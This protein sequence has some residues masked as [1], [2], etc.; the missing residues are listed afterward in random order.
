MRNRVDFW[1][2]DNLTDPAAI[3]EIDWAR[4]RR[5]YEAGA[6]RR[7]LLAKVELPPSE[8]RPRT[9]SLVPPPHS[10]PAMAEGASQADVAAYVCE[11]LAGLIGVAASMLLLLNGRIAGVSGIL[12][13]VF[14]TIGVAERFWR[15]AFVI[16][17]VCGAFL[18]ALA[19]DG[20]TME[21]PRSHLLLLVAGFLVGVG[22]R[23][24]SGCTSGHGVCGLARRSPR[25]LAATAT[26]LLFG[27]LTVFLMRHITSF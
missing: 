23:L 3:A 9:M 17:L 18:Y 8:P 4:F 14:G 16:G 7:R 10:C 11:T 2:E 15:V 13:G 27:T 26:F 12:G 24:G 5:L 25:S 19:A 20:L 6:P 22:T 21:L 1:S